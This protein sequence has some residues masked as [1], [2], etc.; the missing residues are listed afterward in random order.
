MVGNWP[1]HL[2]SLFCMEKKYVANKAVIVNAQ[3]KVLLLRDS[4]KLDHQGADGKWDF[5]GGRM[6]HGETPRE[7]LLRE[8]QE[9]VALSPQDVQ[10][11][12]PIY[13]GL[14]EAGGD[15]INHPIVG[16]FYIVRLVGNPEIQLSNEHDELRWI[17]PRQNPPN[18]DPLP[19]EEVIDA[20]RVHEG[21]VVAVDES[22]K[23]REGFGLVQVF[24][25]NGKGKTT[26]AIGE[27]V[28][29]VG[30]GKCAAVIFFDKGGAHYS[31]RSI[32]E[33]LGVPWFAYGRDRIDPVTGRFDF[34]I[35]EEDR[36]LGADGLSKALELLQSDQY[37]LL[38]LDEINSSTD[39][40][41]VPETELLS[42]ID[43]KP[44]HIELVLTGRNAPQSFIDRAHLVTE[45]RLRKHYFYSGVKAR[46]G[47]DY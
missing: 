40:G 12:P 16:I 45:M 23:G 19:G 15:K 32:L 20:Y 3:G 29:S 1:V 2:L 46:E 10:I 27:V 5:P 39:L 13:V 8:L 22:I 17:D 26:A 42:L 18:S 35:T 31:E 36:R 7:G 44:D 28:R 11:G 30:A 33:Q 14:W 6:D 47:L 43:Q 37:D 24:T 38:V 41:I 4:G 21:I 25:G 34:S 9:E